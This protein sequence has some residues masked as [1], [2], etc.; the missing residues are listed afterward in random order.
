MKKFI[1]IFMVIVMSLTMVGAAYAYPPCPPNYNPVPQY[2]YQ[3]PA[4]YYDG[5]RY[6]RYNDNTGY[7]I[8]GAILLGSIIVGSMNNH[9]KEVP[10]PQPTVVYQQPAPTVVVQQPAPTVVVQQPSNVVV[11]T[12]QSNIIS[13]ETTTTNFTDGTK[14]VE[15]ITVYRTSSGSQKHTK[16]VYHYANGATS[17]TERTVNQ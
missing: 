10:Q 5:P 13:E 16:I 6:E 4:P 11:E 15:T 9:P 8:A 14:R 12:P 1:S 2:H 3:A 17:V 7:A